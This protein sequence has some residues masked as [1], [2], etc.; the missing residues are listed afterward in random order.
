MTHSKNCVPS[1][2]E[3]LALTR[4]EK[5]S[6]SV[7]KSHLLHLRDIVR[8]LRLK[9]TSSV[10]DASSAS[11]LRPSSSCVVGVCCRWF[12]ASV[13]GRRLKARPRSACTKFERCQTPRESNCMA[14]ASL[15]PCP[16]NRD[17]TPAS[18]FLPSPVP[19]HRATQT[20]SAHSVALASEHDFPKGR[21][22]CSA[23]R[24]C[25]SCGF[26]ALPLPAKLHACENQES[27]ACAA[28]LSYPGDSLQK[29]NPA[30]QCYRSFCHMIDPTNSQVSVGLCSCSALNS[31]ATS[32]RSQRNQLCRW[33]CPTE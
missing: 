20:T 29:K 1:R 31:V 19:V 27:T 11:S 23:K 2:A 16:G 25:Q 9:P 17:R 22:Y 8:E 21:R 28:D 10:F 33:E 26:C 15:L 12:Y 3:Q 30:R 13:D 32:E 14:S 24:K 18:A 6:M 4:C 5:L 7:R